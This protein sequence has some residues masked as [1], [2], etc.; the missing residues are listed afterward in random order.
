M[1]FAE[2]GKAFGLE[3][4]PKDSNGWSFDFNDES[5]ELTVNIKEKMIEEQKLSK[6]QLENLEHELKEINVGL[7]SEIK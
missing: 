5:K 4:T 7:K 2:F 3:F 1:G 6:E